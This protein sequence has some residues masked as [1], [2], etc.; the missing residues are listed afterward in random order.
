MASSSPTARRSLEDTA[1]F[2]EL[3]VPVRIHGRLGRRAAS[4]P[5][6]VGSDAA[7]E[8]ASGARGGKSRR[9]LRDLGRLLVCDGQI[10]FTAHATCARRRNFAL[11]AFEAGEFGR[12]GEVDAD[13]TVVLRRRPVVAKSHSPALAGALA[14]DAP[15]RVDFGVVVRGVPTAPRSTLSCGPAQAPSSV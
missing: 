11:Y 15:P 14:C 4:P 8:F 9:W 7:H 2:L 13:G 10:A 1:W 5:N 6:T 12:W 3:V